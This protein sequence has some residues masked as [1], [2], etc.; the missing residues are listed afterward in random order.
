MYD[1]LDVKNIDSIL[2]PPQPPQPMDPA[3]E[4]SMALKGQQLQAFPQQDSMAH[5]VFTLL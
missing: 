3:T 4:N 1:A 2:P 5:I